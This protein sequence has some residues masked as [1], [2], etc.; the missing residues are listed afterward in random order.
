M[1]IAVCTSEKSP[2]ATVCNRFG[3]AEYFAVY[4]TLS[5]DWQYYANAQDTQAAQ[6]AGIQSAQT[7]IDSGAEVLVAANV[8]PKAMRALT[9]NKVKVFAAA[10][11]KTLTEQIALYESGKLT[12]MT[13]ANVEGH[14]V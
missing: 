3:R 9:A 4:D 8:G 10:V 6:G 12:E 11:T 5:K 13:M 1:K 14:W 7:I 2:H